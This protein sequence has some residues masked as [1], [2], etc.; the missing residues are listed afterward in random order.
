MAR[1]QPCSGSI[2]A[3]EGDGV[4]GMTPGRVDIGVKQPSA[5]IPVRGI[6]LLRLRLAVIVEP[7]PPRGHPRRIAFSSDWQRDFRASKLERRVSVVPKAIDRGLAAVACEPLSFVA[8]L[9]SAVPVRA[10]ERGE[11]RFARYGPSSTA[12]ALGTQTPSLRLCRQVLLC[13]DT[14]GSRRSTTEVRLHPHARERLQE[15]G[16]SEREVGATVT[17]GESFP[18]KDGRTGFRRKFQFD[19]EW[20]V[21]RYSTKQVEVYALYE[22]GWLVIPVT[23]KF[24]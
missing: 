18:A 14:G 19:A 16:A 22:N 8:R 2:G 1:R 4:Q 9:H 6:D 3:L 23:V 7:R 15:R 5:G 10:F 11:R 12:I 21:G 17:Q 24:F 13:Q 20:N